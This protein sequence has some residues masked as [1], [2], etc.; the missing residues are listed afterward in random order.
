MRWHV[1][2]GFA[3]IIVIIILLSPAIASGSPPLLTAMN[4]VRAAHGLAPLRLD[5][6][7]QR[8]ARAHSSDMIRRN[9]FA[10]GPFMSRLARFGVRGPRVGENLAWGVGAGADPRGVVQRWLAS[11]PHRAN[12]LRRGFRRVGIGLLVGQFG[13]YSRAAVMT[14]DFAGR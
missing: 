2:A 9:Y 8:A 13:G 14:A 10:H 11:P 1:A 3:A 6:R 4:E 7:L 12:L 5:P